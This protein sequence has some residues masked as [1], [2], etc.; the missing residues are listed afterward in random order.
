MVKKKKK[1]NLLECMLGMI[2]VSGVVFTC[3]G[4]RS[5]GS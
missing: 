3:W 2:E 5:E 1:L 4:G